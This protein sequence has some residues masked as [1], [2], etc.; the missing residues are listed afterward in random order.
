MNLD[1]ELQRLFADDRLDVPVRPGATEAVVA[2]ARRVRRRRV[3]MT[4]VGGA[5]ALSLLAG[6]AIVLA[7]PGPTQSVPG[8]DASVSTTGH[9]TASPT[10]RSDESAPTSMNAPGN[11]GTRT[12]S[13]TGKPP[14]SSAPQSTGRPD[15]GTM[16]FGPDGHLA[17]R[18]GMTAE[19]AE[20]TGLI[21]P[22][23]QP[24]SSKG[25]KGYDYKG[26]PKDAAHY[27]V[28]ISP[29]YGLVR[30]ANGPRRAE[31]A[32]GINVDSSE[33]DMKKAYPISAGSHGAVGEWV[34][35]VPGH[36]D[37]RYWFL[38]RDGKVAEMRLELATQDCYA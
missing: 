33:S 38:V 8:S 26:L 4:A 1:D 36:A 3:V 20:A 17:L 6:T 29:T 5:A 28:L 22:N 35:Q 19:E 2:G 25:C 13:V 23:V 37:K 10:E 27:A 16:A 24:V 31:T 12:G 30:L 18:L 14:A 7:K 15:D 32:E 34:T 9:I 21:T 11:S